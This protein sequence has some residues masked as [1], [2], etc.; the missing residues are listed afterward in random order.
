MTDQCNP[1]NPL[2]YGSITDIHDNIIKA[3]T[4]GE[5][6]AALAKVRKAFGK[7]ND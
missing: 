1:D 6:D 3:F 2:P 7:R 5:E 4:N